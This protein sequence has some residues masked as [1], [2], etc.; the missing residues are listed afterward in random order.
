MARWT[1]LV[2]DLRTNVILGE[3]P[4]T[5]P[6]IGKWLNKSG[7]LQ[8]ATLPLSDPRMSKSNVRDWTTPGH[9]VLYA[10][11][12]D[13]PWWGGVIWTQSYDSATAKVTIGCGDFW[14]YFDHRKILPVLAMP[15][16]DPHYVATQSVGYTA[17][18]QNQIARNL[19]ALAQTHAGGD[20]GIV[21]DAST[22]ATLRDRSY[23][24]FELKTVATGLAEL[25]GVIGG[26]DIIFDVGPFDANGRPTR[27]LRLGTPHIGQ[28]G[29]PHVWEYGG[30][31]VS[32]TWPAD[33]TRMRTRTYAVGDGID[34]GALIAVSEDATKYADGWALLEDETGYTTVA[35]AA[36]LQGHAGAD[37][38]LGSLP[39]VLPT[40][41]VAGGMNPQPGNYNPGDDA[42]VI[43][44]DLFFP[45]GL[46]TSMR[47]IGVEITPTD[48]VEMPVLTMS[49]LL[50][51]VS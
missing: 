3:L 11:R 17:V 26:P 4:M 6:R 48:G 32:Y 14:S 12:D 40:L 29:S 24:G 30:N 50:D 13:T 51:D 19:V 47:I 44:R 7:T 2:A 20:I 1:Y 28:V 36:V 10:I 37:L 22:S 5:G 45:A 41:T 23:F 42:R 9:R 25:A 43:I 46:D 18:E 16:T 34:Q 39:V 27:I 49:P 35:D 8:G 31:L 38:D 21:M 15:V 33:G